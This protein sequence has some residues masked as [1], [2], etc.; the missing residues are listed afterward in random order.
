MIREIAHA[1]GSLAFALLGC[2]AAE[3]TLVVR[4]DSDL[5]TAREQGGRLGSVQIDV[6]SRGQM[7]TTPIRFQGTGF[8]LPGDHVV[9]LAPSSDDRRVR[10]TVTGQTTDGLTLRRPFVVEVPAGETRVV[11]VFLAAACLSR[12]DC[13]SGTS[14]GAGGRC[15]ASTNPPLRPY[16]PLPQ[17]DAGPPVDAADGACEAPPAVDAGRCYTTPACSRACPVAAAEQSPSLPAWRVTHFQFTRP[18]TLATRAVNTVVNSYIRR[19]DAVAGFQIDRARNILRAGPL[20]LQAG[21]QGL[22]LLDGMYRFYGRGE[23]PIVQ[24]FRDPDRWEVA[25]LAIRQVGD[26]LESA[27]LTRPLQ[28]PFSSDVGTSELPAHNFRMAAFRFGPNPSCIG[29]AEPVS[30]RFNECDSPWVTVDDEGRGWLEI[31]GRVPVEFARNYSIIDRGTTLCSLIAG[32]SDCTRVPMAQW[33]Q[34]PDTE[35]GGQPAW[36]LGAE[37]AAVRAQIAEGAAGG[38]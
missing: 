8:V 13:P 34:Q 31:E 15:E 20:R 23:A 19:S 25:E 3:S 30:L 38:P 11:E 1:V 4:I 2:S 27:T 16:T 10:L 17:R 14:C 24:G 22:G 21:T 37:L 12:T 5:G 6:S 9:H 32:V 18:P 33:R 35:V 7:Q 28:I 29:T 26:H 36:T